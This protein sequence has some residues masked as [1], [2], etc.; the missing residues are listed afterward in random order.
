[1]KPLNNDEATPERIAALQCVADE[2]HGEG[3]INIAELLDD[4]TPVAEEAPFG[5]L[6]VAD[7]CAPDDYIG[8]ELCDSIIDKFRGLY[9][10]ARHLAARNLGL[11]LHT[12]HGM[13][14]WAQL[15]RCIDRGNH[16]YRA[17]AALPPG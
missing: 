17:T 2:L 7:G 8:E 3:T 11:D 1:V 15:P 16:G 6:E 5:I 13:Y 10:A 4:P 12:P 9:A 14:C